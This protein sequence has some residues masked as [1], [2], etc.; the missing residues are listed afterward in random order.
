MCGCI[1]S[2]M[3]LA[4]GWPSLIPS[5]PP[6]ITPSTS[7]T[8]TTERDPAPSA[9]TARSMVW[10]AS[11]SPRSSARAQMPLVRRSRSCSLHQLEEICLAALLLVQP[12]YVSSIAARPAYASMQ[13]IRPHV[14]RAPSMLDHHV[15]DLARAASSDPGLAVEDQTAAHPVP[16]NTPSSDRA[17]RPAPSLNSALVATCTSLPTATGSRARVRASRPAGTRPPTPA[18]CEHS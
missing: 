4:Y 18:G 6:M 12:A 11:L 14:H 5:P 2:A 9:L 1:A 13:P 17:D 8:L 3:R 16:Q 10:I 15:A 7:S